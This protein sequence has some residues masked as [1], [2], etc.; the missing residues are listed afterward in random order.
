MDAEIPAWP[1]M[2]YTLGILIF[3]E[4]MQDFLLCQ[5][6]CGGIDY[7]SGPVPAENQ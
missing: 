5:Q 6:C 3:F 4:V 1:E 7:F 2:P